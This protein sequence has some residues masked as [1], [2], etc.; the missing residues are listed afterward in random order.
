MIATCP[1]CATR[2]AV[3]RGGADADGS[4]MRCTACGHG[5]IEASAVDMTVIEDL[6]MPLAVVDA[7]TPDVMAEAR[8]IARAARLAGEQAA[9]R[10]QARL[11]A[12]RG[13]AALAASV[14]ATLGLLA[15]FPEAVVR[16]AP[17]AAAFYE[18]AG[19][20]VNLR[21]FEIGNVVQQMLLADGEPVLAVR[22]EVANVSGGDLKVPA[23]RFVIADADGRPVH[24]W[25]LNAVATR[26]LAAGEKTSFVTR[27]AAPPEAGETIEIRFAR[28]DE[29]GSNARP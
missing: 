13:W 8:R 10:R 28:A 15:T 17:A 21:G 23:L 7:A 19:I 18:K 27:L 4:V 3:P 11:A 6:S 25:T 26:P 24:A 16:A 5:W 20:A 22:G 12:L 1:S 2:Q 29:M 9:R 14:A